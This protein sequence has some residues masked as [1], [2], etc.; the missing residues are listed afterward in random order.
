[1]QMVP[2]YF[3]FQQ[4]GGGEGFIADAW[5]RGCATCIEEWSGYEESTPAV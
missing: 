1:M 3:G 2:L 5:M 4:L